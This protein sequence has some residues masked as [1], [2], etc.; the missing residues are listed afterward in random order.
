M[1]KKIIPTWEEIKLWF[2]SSTGKGV[3]MTWKGIANSVIPYI[4]LLGPFVGI[5][6]TPGEL[7]PI[8]EGISTVLIGLWGLFASFQVVYGAIRKLVIRVRNSRI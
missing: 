4:V 8:I 6:V 3:S 1:I 5:D 7:N 2:R